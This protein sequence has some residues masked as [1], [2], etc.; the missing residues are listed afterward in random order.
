MESY[1][2]PGQTGGRLIRELIAFWRSSA[3]FPDLS[4]GSQILSIAC[5]GGSDSVAAAHLLV[6]YGRRIASRANLRLLHIDHGWR[7]DESRADAAYVEKLA[8]EW[9]VAF[10]KHELPPLGTGAAKGESL[11][12]LAREARNRIYDQQP[13]FVLTAHTAD[14]LAE[15]LL[16]RLAAGEAETHGGGIARRHGRVLRP[17]LFV[18]KETFR[19]Y[20]REESVAWRED[21]TNHEGRF[22]RSKMRSGLMPMLEE[23]F[24]RAIENLAALALDAQ[25][26]NLDAARQI[27]DGRLQTKHS[28]MASLDV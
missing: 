7:G 11:E 16:W 8:A 22:L 20:L 17:F 25:D 18:R 27:R 28:D 1:P 15:T 10:E 13:G 3:D 14:D 23:I 4:L 21:R 26:Q 19:Q 2:K 9:G 12:K 5:S 6:R 24:P